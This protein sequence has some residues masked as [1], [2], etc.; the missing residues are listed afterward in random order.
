M[1]RLMQGLASFD[2]NINQR[3]TVPRC[4]DTDSIFIEY[5]PLL[6]AVTVLDSQGHKRLAP[7]H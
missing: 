7:I 3:L 5:F 4:T 1:V 6:H 2:S